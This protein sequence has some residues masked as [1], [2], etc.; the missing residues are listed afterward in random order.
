MT[1]TET[2]M[3]T[4]KA[5]AALM[6]ARPWPGREK[7]PRKVEEPHRITAE[8]VPATRPVQPAV[9]VIRF[10]NMPRMNVANSGALKKPNRVWR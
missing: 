3:S 8:S 10:Q 2:T 5:V 7:T 6:N 4:T 1:A 9:G